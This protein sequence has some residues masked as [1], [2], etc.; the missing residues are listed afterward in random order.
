MPLRS[1][2]D[3]TWVTLPRPYRGDDINRCM[4][5]LEDF[6]YTDK[7]GFTHTAKAGCIVDGKTTP[8][9][10]W[11]TYL[12][13]PPYV[14]RARGPSIIH[15]WGCDLAEA[16]AGTRP[17]DLDNI[18]A[19]VDLRRRY[20]QLY[21]EMLEFVGLLPVK[22]IVQ[23]RAVRVGAAAAE[24][25]WMQAYHAYHANHIYQGQGRHGGAK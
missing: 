4:R 6:S 18:R 3:A 23:Y 20:D 17:G 22:R 10:V 11:C 5:L 12:A 9:P 19:A 7:A 24:Q 13:G 1:F 16:L 25:R 15:D 8:R 2:A 21:L 14:D